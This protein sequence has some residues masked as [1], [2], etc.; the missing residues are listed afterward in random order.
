MHM[1]RSGTDL[2]QGNGYITGATN[3]RQ[4]SLVCI[5]YHTYP[6]QSQSTYRKEE[7]LL[8]STI[9][10]KVMVDLSFPLA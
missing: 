7:P 4:T 3:S 9:K 2:G 10:E 1:H 6:A 5:Q 8:S